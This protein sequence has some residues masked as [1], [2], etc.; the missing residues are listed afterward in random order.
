[1]SISFIAKTCPLDGNG[2]YRRA[3]VSVSVS[4]AVGAEMHPATHSES[5]LSMQ[6]ECCSQFSQPFDDIRTPHLPSLDP[7]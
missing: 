2:W 1:M 7:N 3:E 6:Q 4:V 5:V